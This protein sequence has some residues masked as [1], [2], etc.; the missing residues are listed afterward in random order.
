MPVLD[1]TDVLNRVASATDRFFDAAE[2]ANTKLSGATVSLVDTLAARVAEVDVPFADRIP[3]IDLP[4]IDKLPEPSEAVTSTFDLIGTG[5]AFNRTV[6]ERMLD[7]ITPGADEVEA[8]AAE[9]PA[10]KKAAAKKPA[11]K[12]AATAKKKA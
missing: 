9:K 3:S 12:K 2:A 11:A 8:P 5:I 1:Q 4:L 10:A 6:A 7:A